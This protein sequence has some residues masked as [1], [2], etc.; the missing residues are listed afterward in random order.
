MQVRLDNMSRADILTG[1]ESSFVSNNV[2]GNM[3]N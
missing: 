2:Y 3:T 1:H